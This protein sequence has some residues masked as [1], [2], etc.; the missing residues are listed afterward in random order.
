M[1]VMKIISYVVCG[2]GLLGGLVML[3]DGDTADAVMGI[4]IYGFFLALTVN[5]KN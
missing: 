4:L 1:K 2:I 5:I 3:V